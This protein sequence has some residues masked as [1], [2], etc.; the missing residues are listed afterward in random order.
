MNNAQFF[1]KTSSLHKNN[2]KIVIC[3]GKTPYYP[4]FNIPDCDSLDVPALSSSS[5][6]AAGSGL[7]LVV[8]FLGTWQKKS[9]IVRLLM[10][11]GVYEFWENDAKK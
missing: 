11:E 7:G 10:I 6:T 4:H 9:V 1:N 3:V 2:E 8:F 5:A